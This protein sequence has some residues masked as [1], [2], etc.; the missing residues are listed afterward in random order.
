MKFCIVQSWGRACLGLEMQ[1]KFESTITDLHRS[2]ANMTTIYETNRTLNWYYTVW[3]QVSNRR[4]EP[5]VHAW[6]GMAHVLHHIYV[7]LHMLRRL[8]NFR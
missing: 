8:L 1:I 6:S 5:H 2:A 3:N 7:V 4:L